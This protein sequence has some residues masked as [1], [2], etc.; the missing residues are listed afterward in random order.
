MQHCKLQSQLSFSDNVT[1]VLQKLF[2]VVPPELKS[3]A[4][5]DKLHL[6]RGPSSIHPAHDVIDG[7]TVDI[8]DY[9]TFTDSQ[10]RQTS[11]K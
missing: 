2:L 7:E 5:N 1:I 4:K 9:Q 3:Q 11:Y 6:S 10:K 8:R